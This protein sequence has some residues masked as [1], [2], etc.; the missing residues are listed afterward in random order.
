MGRAS[1]D[2]GICDKAICQKSYLLLASCE[3]TVA[4][5]YNSWVQN[6]RK[7]LLKQTDSWL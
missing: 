1:Y 3:D 5:K 7:M 4:K 2:I 6:M